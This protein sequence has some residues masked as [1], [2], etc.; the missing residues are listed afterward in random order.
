[1]KSR[2]E[3]YIEPDVK[4]TVYEWSLHSQHGR[5]VATHTT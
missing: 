2:Q 5:S 4:W 1:M 3:L